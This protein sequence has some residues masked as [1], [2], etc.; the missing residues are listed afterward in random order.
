MKFIITIFF[1][2]SVLNAGFLSA[3]QD[4]TGK[5]VT[6]SK[7]SEII[8]EANNP[9][10]IKSISPDVCD[11]VDMCCCNE[12][13]C[14]GGN[15]NQHKMS[16]KNHCEDKAHDFVSANQKSKTQSFNKIF[17]R[18]NILFIKADT[19]N[20]IISQKERFQSAPTYILS[21]SFLI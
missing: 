20:T 1:Y 3:H 21:Q 5:N 11:D 13:L 19:R 14:M 15:N 7:K 17:S 2:T 8:S 4:H 6:G 10:D 18:T 9:G 16:C 12:D